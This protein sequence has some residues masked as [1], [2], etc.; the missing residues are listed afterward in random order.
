MKFFNNQSIKYKIS[1]ALILPILGLLFFS[2]SG[3]R[4]NWDTFSETEKI[5]ALTHL[6]VSV[7]RLVH[8]LQKER[9]LTAGFLGSKG[10]E[11]VAALQKQR[12]DTDLRMRALKAFLSEFDASAHGNQFADAFRDANTHIER[13][14]SI[15][16]QV[17]SLSISTGEAINYYTQNNGLFLDLVAVIPHLSQ[18]GEINNISVAYA[19]YLYGKERAGIERAVLAGVFS[20]DA[21]GANTLNRL[22]G[23]ITEQNVYQSV[24]ESLA[25]KEALRFY[26][27]TLRGQAID[28]T[29]RMRE[30]ALTKAAEGNFGV[31]PTYWFEMQ[32]RK[33]NLLKKVEDHL[34]ESLLALAEQYRDQSEAALN[35][36]ITITAA[37]VMIAL[38]AT[39]LI[40]RS[41]G[42]AIASAMRVAEAI[43]KGKLDNAIG[44]TYKDEVGRLLQSLAVMQSNLSESMERERMASRGEMARIKQALNSAT[45]NVMVADNDHNIVYLNDAAKR[46]FHDAQNEFQQDFP[47]F[48]ADTVL[49]S[50]LCGFYQDPHGQ[51]RRLNALSRTE[52]TEL[53]IGGRTIN[54]ISN[55]ITDDEGGRFGTVVEWTDRTNEVTFEREVDQLIQSAKHGE[56]QQRIHAEGKSGFFADLSSG[57]NQL[58]DVIDNAFSHIGRTMSAIAG[59]DPKSGSTGIVLG[60]RPEATIARSTIRSTHSRNDIL[61]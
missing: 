32:T 38:M 9:G 5:L 15:R 17:S 14:A 19:N 25:S 59:F 16:S 11:F 46:L 31:D 10:R 41:I 40:V 56:L 7:S 6:S 24:F 43:T 27:Q 54:V 52:K 48:R 35:L 30:I 1:F 51:A 60:S 21:F 23:L 33:I 36:A 47:G 58:L 18:T 45:T 8:E 26:Q 34:A 29:A 3:I 28:E 57:M 50:S 12:G 61:S 39:F 42:R 22:L 55:P 49:G 2:Q 13:L 20:A 37:V 44:T 53:L 4:K